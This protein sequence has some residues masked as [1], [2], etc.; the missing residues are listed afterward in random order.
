MISVHEWAMIPRVMVLFRCSF[1][2]FYNVN[3]ALWNKTDN[4]LL[5]QTP[6]NVVQGLSTG[7]RERQLLYTALPSDEGDFLELRIT[8][9]HDNTSRLVSID[10]FSMSVSARP[11]PTGNPFEDFMA[12]YPGLTGNDAL[13]G[14]DPDGDG[15]SNVAEFIMGGTAPNSG[16]AANRPVVRFCQIYCQLCASNVI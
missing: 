13:P 15:L 5:V 10:T 8:E 6:T 12:N 4:V 11:P 7:C 3:I 1:T 14:A 9:N 16:S 2:S